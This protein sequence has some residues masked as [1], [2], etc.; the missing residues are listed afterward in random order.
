MVDVGLNKPPIELNRT[1]SIS[2]LFN[3]ETYEINA[4]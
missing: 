2:N 1:L 3:I 4:T